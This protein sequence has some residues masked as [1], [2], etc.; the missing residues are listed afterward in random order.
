MN[1]EGSELNL[2]IFAIFLLLFNVPS[3]QITPANPLV[4]PC[5]N[6]TMEHHKRH[7]WEC[8]RR[9]LVCD[10]AQ[11]S[12]QR[13]LSAGTACPG[14]GSVKPT[15][16]RWLEP[17]KVASRS[18]KANKAVTYGS[19]GQGGSQE[20]ASLSQSEKLAISRFMMQ[21]DFCVFSQTVQYCK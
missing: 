21:T 2:L 20:A 6:H 10:S 18:S 13:C 19:K 17:G 16:L 12:C 14:Y 5:W 9:C 7:C 8:L 11:P 15:R 1:L 4:E 3:A